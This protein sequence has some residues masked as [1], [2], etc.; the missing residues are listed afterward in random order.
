MQGK[1]FKPLTFIGRYLHFSSPNDCFNTHINTCFVRI[2]HTTVCV[3]NVLKIKYYIFGKCY[4]MTYTNYMCHY[5]YWVWTPPL[6]KIF[7]QRTTG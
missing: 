5:G 3:I 7:L 2:C 6:T 4:G 1:F